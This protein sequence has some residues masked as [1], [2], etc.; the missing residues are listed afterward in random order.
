MESDFAFKLLHHLVLD[1]FCF[2]D[3]FQGN[4]ESSLNMPGEVHL[5]EFSLAELLGNFEP[6]DDVF[7]GSLGFDWSDAPHIVQ[8][9]DLGLLRL[10][11]GRMGFLRLN[12]LIIIQNLAVTLHL[13]KFLL[14]AS[15]YIGENSPNFGIHVRR[16]S[17]V[18][19]LEFADDTR[20]RGSEVNR[21]FLLAHGLEI[22]ALWGHFP[23]PD[24]FR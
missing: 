6:I 16:V 21:L 17:Q 23:I 5:T 10:G 24:F 3:F 18:V 1:H 4:N 15:A 20:T 11:L 9:P 7:L 12:L 13:A 2:D 19:L 22:E 8:R 14:L